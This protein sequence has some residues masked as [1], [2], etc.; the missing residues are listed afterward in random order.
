MVLVYDLIFGKGIQCGGPLKRVMM[1][2]KEELKLLL[3]NEDCSNSYSSPG[4]LSNCAFKFYFC[5]LTMLLAY[6]T[7]TCVL[8]KYAR[9]N[10]LK[11]TV[12]DVV[13]LLQE[14]NYNMLN[15]MDFLDHFR[16]CS[17][18]IQ[19]TPSTFMSKSPNNSFHDVFC[20]DSHLDDVLMFC[21][22][23]SLTSTALYA[24]SKLIL[25]DKVATNYFSAGLL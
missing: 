8:P 11:V 21:P 13:L 2:H 18:E 5:G 20:Q 22:F 7:V 6:F 24:D 16:S 9:V 17:L 4:T 1:K 14:E 23:S 10:L 25:Q 15:R 12:Q 3:N 19:V